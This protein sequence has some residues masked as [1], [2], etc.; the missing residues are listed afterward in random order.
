MLF[1]ALYFTFATLLLLYGESY[2]LPPSFDQHYSYVVHIL[3]GLSVLTVTLFLQ[4][5]VFKFAGK[6]TKA[7]SFYICFIILGYWAVSFY[8]WIEP[9]LKYVW[10]SFTPLLVYLLLSY[11]DRDLLKQTSSVG[12]LTGMVNEYKGA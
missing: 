12:A 8:L 11:V 4:H 9:Q 6:K 5:D 7:F 3:S 1:S 10:I 2:Y